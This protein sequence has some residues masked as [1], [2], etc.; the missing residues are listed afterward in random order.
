MY[1]RITQTKYRLPDI[2][3]TT[4]QHDVLEDIRHKYDLSVRYTYIYYYIIQSIV[5]SHF[6]H[7]FVLSTD[8][9]RLRLHAPAY[10]YAYT[11][12]REMLMMGV[13]KYIYAIRYALL[14]SH[15]HLP[16]MVPH[17]P[18]VLSVLACIGPHIR[19]AYY[20]TYYIS[21]LRDVYDSPIDGI[22]GHMN[23][24]RRVISM[25][26]VYVDDPNH[27]MEEER[28]QRMVYD[29]VTME[30]MRQIDNGIHSDKHDDMNGK[31]S[32]INRYKHTIDDSDVHIKDMHIMI[33]KGGVSYSDIIPYSSH[34][35]YIDRILSDVYKYRIL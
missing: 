2:T 30:Y 12:M 20:Y 15:S 6:H 27:K 16:Y 32:Y 17:L 8:Y 22:R 14:H 34:A 35:Q 9:L 29:D 1:L 18:R 24:I 33:M 23:E 4:S 28:V 5:S 7:L 11:I 10:D 31:I 21:Y 3:L 26:Q 25:I 19:N 13:L